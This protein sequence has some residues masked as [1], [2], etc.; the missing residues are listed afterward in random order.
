MREEEGVN[1]KKKEEVEIQVKGHV[2]EM[3]FQDS[4]WTSFSYGYILDTVIHLTLA[5][6]ES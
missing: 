1:L 3:R 2:A 4:T 5:L 6:F